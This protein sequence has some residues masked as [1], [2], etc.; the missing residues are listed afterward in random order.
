MTNGWDKRERRGFE[1]PPWERDKFEEIARQREA[2]EAE[3]AQRRAEAQAARAAKEA[4]EA[5]GPSES[6]MAAMVIQLRGEEPRSPK[7]AKALTLAV[8]AFM[9]SLGAGL[10]GWSA[11]AYAG[12]R[13]AGLPALVGSVIVMLMG[14]FFLG[15]S[16]FLWAR[17]TRQQGE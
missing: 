11:A 17:A 2:A 1:P 7:G 10:A 14:L 4:G 6:E 3:E 16:V 12:A 15:V 9:L 13:D 5:A 8:A